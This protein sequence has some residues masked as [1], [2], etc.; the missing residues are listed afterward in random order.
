MSRPQK[1]KSSIGLRRART[2][3]VLAAALTLTIVVLAMSC[4]YQNG[5]FHCPGL[6]VLPLPS[7]QWFG[8]VALWQGPTADFVPLEEPWVPGDSLRKFYPNDYHPEQDVEP[9]TCPACTCGPPEYCTSPMIWGAFNVDCAEVGDMQPAQ[10]GGLP[11]FDHGE[12]IPL[13]EVASSDTACFGTRKVSLTGCS[14]VLLEEP[15]FPS[16]APQFMAAVYDTFYLT[17]N[18][19]TG[20]DETCM[21]PLPEGYEL[22]AAVKGDLPC[23]GTW[24]NA[25]RYVLMDGFDD[26]RK[27][28]DCPCG[29]P[30]SAG[31]CTVKVEAF[32]DKECMNQVT[33]GLVYL[34]DDPL[35]MP[36]V[37]PGEVASTRTEVV[38]FDPPACDPPPPGTTAKPQGEIKQGSPV[39]FCCL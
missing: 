16:P 37:P 20:R 36:V 24:A 15:V 39:T 28:D 12:C 4:S 26:S 17:P 21:H 9:F 32:S 5:P 10:Q 33:E 30:T 23:E 31:E 1:E 8:P 34:G 29:Q 14:S 7:E 3:H 35:L 18:D 22:C 27:C 25:K 19:C 13:D 6:C 11:N 38:M 2:A